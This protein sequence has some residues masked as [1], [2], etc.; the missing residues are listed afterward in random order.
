MRRSGLKPSF[1]KLLTLQPPPTQAEVLIKYGNTEPSVARWLKLC[2]D[3]AASAT[4][5]AFE[6]RMWA[7]WP[8]QLSQPNVVGVGCDEVDAWVRWATGLKERG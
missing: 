8:A 3:D 5:A 6:A 7:T 2:E 1:T 4:S